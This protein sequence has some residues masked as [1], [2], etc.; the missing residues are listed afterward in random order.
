[1]VYSKDLRV[2][3]EQWCEN[4]LLHKYSTFR[5]LKKFIKNIYFFVTVAFVN[6]VDSRSMYKEKTRDEQS[7]KSQI[8]PLQ[9]GMFRITVH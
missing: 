1:M 2:N 4:L 6:H 7:E 3:K 9:K 8:P 5:K